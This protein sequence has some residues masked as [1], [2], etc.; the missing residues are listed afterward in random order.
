MI[1]PHQYHVSQ[2]KDRY[3][4]FEIHG[5]MKDRRCAGNRC[6]AKCNA[7]FLSSAEFGCF[8]KT[9]LLTCSLMQRNRLACKVQ[10]SCCPPLLLHILSCSG[11][12]INKK[13][14]NF[15]VPFTTRVNYPQ[16]CQPAG[17][18]LGCMSVVPFKQ[19]NPMFS[20]VCLL[21]RFMC[22]CVANSV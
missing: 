2:N 21:H 16:S 14:I 15:R 17:T 1:S 4:S 19:H 12:A 13:L 11:F 9:T 8:L 5:H 6:D 18:S 7:T 20:I 3:L 10:A 22:V